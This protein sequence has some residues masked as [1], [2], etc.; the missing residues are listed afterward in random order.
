MIEDCL[1]C[2]DEQNCLGNQTVADIESLCPT[3]GAEQEGCSV[4]ILI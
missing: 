1:Y 4:I 2:R 3:C